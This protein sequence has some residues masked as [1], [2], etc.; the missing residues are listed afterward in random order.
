LWVD[1]PNR[2]VILRARIGDRFDAEIEERPDSDGFWVGLVDTIAECGDVTHHS[3]L[4]EA[5][6]HVKSVTGTTD[7]AWRR[8]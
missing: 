7:I 4:E 5:K 8:R 1:R 2:W 6:D 3:T